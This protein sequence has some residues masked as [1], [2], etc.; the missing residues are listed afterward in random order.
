LVM[1]LLISISSPSPRMARSCHWMECPLL[2]KIARSPK[3]RANSSENSSDLM[4][5][6]GTALLSVWRAISPITKVLT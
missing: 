1:E 3:V 6:P 2:G 4:I 5:K